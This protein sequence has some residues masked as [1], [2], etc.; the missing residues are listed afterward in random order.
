MSIFN[1]HRA[2]CSPAADSQPRLV[3][4]N[5]SELLHLACQTG[6]GAGVHEKKNPGNQKV[7]PQSYKEVP[8]SP[9][10]VSFPAP[11]TVQ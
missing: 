9:S 1:S 10:L 3:G 4:L 6:A 5:R 11:I 2:P 8:C 7:W